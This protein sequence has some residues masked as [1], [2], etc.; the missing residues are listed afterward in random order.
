MLTLPK[1]SSAKFK[2]AA[3]FPTVPIANDTHRS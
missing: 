2:F 3:Q 1:Y